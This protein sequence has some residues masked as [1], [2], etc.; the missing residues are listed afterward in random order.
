MPAIQVFPGLT[1]EVLAAGQNLMIVKFAFEKGIRVPVHRHIH[2]QSSYVVKGRLQYTIEGK[3][4]VLEAGQ[5]L[6]V[7]PN[8]DHSAVALE[9]TVDINSF[10]PIRED[11][12]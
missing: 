1:R 4:I 9:E 7:P 11:Y 8:T 2:E 6:I 3:E 12:L 5:S 10:T